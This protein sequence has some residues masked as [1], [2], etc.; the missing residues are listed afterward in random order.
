MPA[1]HRWLNSDSHSHSNSSCSLTISYKANVTASVTVLSFLSESMC[2][3]VQ[4]W[5]FVHFFTEECRVWRFPE[6]TVHKCVCNHICMY[7][8]MHIMCACLWGQCVRSSLKFISLTSFCQANKFWAFLSK[9]QK[10]RHV[11]TVFVLGPAGR[12]HW[13]W[14]ASNVRPR[15]PQTCTR[16]SLCQSQHFVCA[17]TRFAHRQNTLQT[18][19]SICR[20]VPA[21]SDAVRM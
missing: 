3:C 8:C 14:A 19:L 13:P 16:T 17:C 1:S 6:N 10:S 11:C 4:S 18:L 15:D 9:W 20:N 2:V 5:K 21:I 12:T 7:A